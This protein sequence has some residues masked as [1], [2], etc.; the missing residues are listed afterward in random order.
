MK[1]PVTLDQ[2]AERVTELERR[3]TRLEQHNCWLRR[4]LTGVAVLGGLTLLAAAQQD[5]PRPVEASRLTMRD[6]AGTVRLQLHVDE[7]G[8][9]LQFH[10][11][12]GRGL[13]TLGTME[14]ALLLQY[15]NKG[16]GRQT[17]IALQKE[18]IALITYTPDGRPQPGRVALLQT[19]GIFTPK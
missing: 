2:L 19:G 11:A 3:N 4:G 15:F 13:A 7:A 10:D 12:K 5:N 17:A 6:A 18:G 9:M 14:D 1:P 16:G 8:P